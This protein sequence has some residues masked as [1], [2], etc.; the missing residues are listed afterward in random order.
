MQGLL[1]PL[2]LR[3]Y[4]AILLLSAPS[5]S[6][7]P[8]LDPFVPHPPPPPSLLSSL[9]SSWPLPLS[10]AILFLPSALFSLSS[11]LPPPPSPL[12]LM[13]AA[14]EGG[15]TLLLPEAP[16]VRPAQST[17]TQ[18]H[19]ALVCLRRRMR[20]NGQLQRLLCRMR[21]R[22]LLVRLQRRRRKGRLLARPLWQMTQRSTAQGDR[23]ALSYN[24]VSPEA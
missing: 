6:R 5:F 10:C 17:D 7:P 20:K 3:V 9:S 14:G 2:P 8:C 12:L 15:S 19:S 22:S 23:E 4:S 11:L 18:Q 21:K 13:F 16:T 24:S 1:H